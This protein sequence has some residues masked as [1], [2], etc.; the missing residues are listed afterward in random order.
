MLLRFCECLLSSY[1]VCISRKV[2]G[3][4][5][6][7]LNLNHKNRESWSLNQFLDLSHFID[8]KHLQ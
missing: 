6:K 4:M 2:L 8:A 1:L 5:R 7:N 3:Q